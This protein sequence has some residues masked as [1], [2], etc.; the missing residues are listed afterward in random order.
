M[1]DLHTPA[2]TNDTDGDA[3]VADEASLG[4]IA[5]E[6][7]ELSVGRGVII[8]VARSPPR[9][10]WRPRSRGVAHPGVLPGRA[11]DHGPGP[12]RRRRARAAD[13]RLARR[14]PRPGRPAGPRSRRAGGRAAAGAAGPLGHGPRRRRRHLTGREMAPREPNRTPGV[15]SD[16]PRPPGP[17][18][19]RGCSSSGTALVPDGGRRA[20]IPRSTLS[21]TY[22]TLAVPSSA[23]RPAMKRAGWNHGQDQK[24]PRGA[25]VALASVFRRTGQRT[26]TAVLERQLAEVEADPAAGELARMLV[27]VVVENRVE[28]DARSR[29]WRRNTWSSSRPR[30]DRSLLRC[31]LRGA[32]FRDAGPGGHRRVG[33]TGPIYSG[34]PMRRLMNGVLGRIARETEADNTP[35]PGGESQWPA[36]TTDSRRS[37]SAAASTRTR[38]LRSVRRRPERRLPRP[39]RADHEPRRVRDRDL[40]RGRREDPD[41]W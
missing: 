2:S 23:A 37:S 35:S 12:E 34:D 27:S 7:I 1:T 6:P 33:R 26:A 16:E 11:A 29:S 41:P 13:H 18:S 21:S 14:G 10:S 9:R 4:P 3:L 39:R 22:G 25:R 5:E 30:M 38:P 40:R 8:E 31:G 36:P 24:P 19:W 20:I 28:I 32:I 15:P 17:R